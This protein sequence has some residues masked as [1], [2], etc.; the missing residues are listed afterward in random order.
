MVTDKH[1]DWFLKCKRGTN[2]TGE[3]CGIIQ[4]LLWLLHFDLDDDKADVIILYDS[5]YAAGVI[6]GIKRAKKNQKV[7]QLAQAQLKQVREQ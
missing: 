1:S 2:N 5:M 7:I 3:L 6:R 4:A